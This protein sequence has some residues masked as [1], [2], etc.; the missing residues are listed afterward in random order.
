MFIFGRLFRFLPRKSSS[1][2]WFED[3][4][5]S[6]RCFW[7]T[8]F[9]FPYYKVM[10]DRETSGTVDAEYSTVALK[11]RELEWAVNSPELL[12]SHKA[13]NGSIIR[14]RFPPEPNGYLHIGHAKSMN[15]NF[16]LAFEKLGVPE[17][18]RRTIFRY[19]D[20]NPEAESAEYIDSLRRDVAWLGWT[21]ERTTYSSDNFQQLHDYAVVLIRKG[22]AYVCDMTKAEM[23]IQ[24]ELAMKR[25]NARNTGKDPDVECPIPSEDILP[26]RNR[27]TSVDCNLELFEKM[28]LGFFN[29]GSYTLRL[30]MDL[31]SSNPN[32]YDLVAYRIKYT[33]HPH[34]GSG[35]CIYPSYDWTHGTCDSLEHIDYSIC[36]LE[37]ETRREPYFWI[38]WA[39]DLYRPNVY[40][41]SRLNLQYTVLSKRRLI[42]LVEKGWV[43]GWDD[44][45]MPT[46]SGLRRRGY[47]AH[48]LNSFCSDVG[49]SR[50]SNVV[51]ITKLQQTAR[52]NLSDTSRRVMAALEPIEVV[53]TNFGTETA[54]DATLTFEVQNSPTDVSRGF[55]TVTLT[56]TIY[57]DSADFRLED[58]PQ[59]YG[60]APNKAVGLK[61]YGGNLVCEKVIQD[62]DGNVV[63]LEGRLDKSENRE[64][65]KTYLSWVPSDGIRCEVRVYN[66]LFTVPEPSDLWEDEVNTES[67]I[68][69]QQAIV[70]P[71]IRDVV[72]VHDID[73]WKSNVSL[74]FERL[75]YF[76]VDYETTYNGA[77]NEGHL[78]FN[79]T[80]TLKE[81]VFKKK[82]TKEEEDKI[83]ARKAQT[84]NDLEA[85]GIRMQIDALNL[86]KEAEEYRGKYSK[87]DAGTGVPTHEVDGTELTKSMMKKLAKEQVKHKKQQLAWNKNNK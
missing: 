72:C 11:G 53:L 34:A 29:E 36:T 2:P 37:F 23:E 38:L 63:Q 7:N 82:L 68:V 12:A 14:T 15:M 28:K 5:N 24:R 58:S 52:V 69:H 75:G 18:H 73:K 70:D 19:D 41:M 44:P 9:L 83:T 32:M 81:E 39:L 40:E 55:H 1:L 10:S 45:R 20:T 57:L 51:E 79:R 42:K 13:V 46:V 78:I 84:K 76:V 87:Y 54:Q 8:L 56:P 67:E 80:V 22:L 27:N 4:Q 3:L 21:P 61:Y 71:S 48:I 35:W 65:P 30:K 31:E 47:T 60:L 66:E 43:R 25:A 86:F 49:A 59:Y 33:A 50:A 6:R 77:T 62:K 16:R 26:G 74:Q 85:K 64:K 17:A